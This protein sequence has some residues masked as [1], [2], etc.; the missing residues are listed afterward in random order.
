[1]REQETTAP[2]VQRELTAE[3]VANRKAFLEEARKLR[4]AIAAAHP[5]AQFDAV[6]DIR[7]GREERDHQLDR[8]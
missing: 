1:M 3:E 6:A 5:D 2:F 8:V 4:E 7:A